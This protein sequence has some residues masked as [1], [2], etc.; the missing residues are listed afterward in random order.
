[1]SSTGSRTVSFCVS[2]NLSMVKREYGQVYQNIRPAL[3]GV[4]RTAF[5]HPLPLP[6]ATVVICDL[7]ERVYSGWLEGLLHNPPRNLGEC[8]QSRPVGF[9]KKIMT[10]LLCPFRQLIVS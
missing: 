2:I 8:R 5:V 6:A 9:P 3:F 7:H 1:M 4:F 10:L